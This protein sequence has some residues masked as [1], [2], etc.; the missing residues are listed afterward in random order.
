MPEL[1]SSGA[2][3]EE[4]RREDEKVRAADENDLEVGVRAQLA[5][6]SPHSGHAGEAASKNYDAPY[7]HESPHIEAW[8]SNSA[9]ALLL[10]GFVPLSVS[11]T[12]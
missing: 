4:E 1:E 7:G 12:T 2:G 5:L 9:D 8:F 6:E 11:K 3:L 10:N